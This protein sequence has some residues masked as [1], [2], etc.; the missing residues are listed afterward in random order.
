MKHYVVAK[1]FSQLTLG[2]MVLCPIFSCHPNNSGQHYPPP[3][4]FMYA[5]V[6]NVRSYWKM[7]DMNCVFAFHSYR[8]V[9][10]GQSRATVIL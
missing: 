10:W 3:Q 1:I 4:Y 5:S 7:N 8:Y 6:L 9:V 2:S